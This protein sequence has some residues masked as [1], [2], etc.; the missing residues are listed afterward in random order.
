MTILLAAIGAL[1]GFLIVALAHEGNGFGTGPMVV[2]ALVVPTLGILTAG[3]AYLVGKRGAVIRGIAVFSTAML[4]SL[5]LV[6]IPWPYPASD[7]PR[8]LSHD[9]QS[10]D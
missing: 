8:P 4:F 1:V 10:R 9:G 3:I 2:A 5:V 6:P 7:G